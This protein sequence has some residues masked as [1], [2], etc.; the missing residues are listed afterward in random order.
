[1]AELLVDPEGRPEPAAVV[2]AVRTTVAP[3]PL[4]VEAVWAD[5]E[6]ELEKEELDACP[7]SSS[8]S[9]AWAVSRLAWAMVSCCCRAMVLRVARVWPAVTC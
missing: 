2:A 3:A 6:L 5:G 7:D 1:V 4:V 9:L 8:L